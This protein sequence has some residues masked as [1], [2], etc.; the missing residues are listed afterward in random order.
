M[1]VKIT[2]TTLLKVLGGGGWRKK[3]TASRRYDEIRF[4]IAREVRIINI[5]HPDKPTKLKTTIKEVRT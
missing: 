1:D 5:L 4:E 2:F 3:R